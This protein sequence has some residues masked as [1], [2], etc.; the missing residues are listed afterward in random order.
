MLL[1]SPACCC[2]NDLSPRNVHPSSAAELCLP[3]SLLTLHFPNLCPL[4]LGSWTLG[5]TEPSGYRWKNKSYHAKGTFKDPQFLSTDSEKE[6]V[7][8]WDHGGQCE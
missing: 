7:S 6:E 4:P 8:S 5:G 3:G 1:I 2:L